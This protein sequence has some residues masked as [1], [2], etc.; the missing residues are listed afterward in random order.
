MKWFELQRQF[1]GLTALPVQK[2]H[3]AQREGWDQPCRMRLD[4]FD[5]DRQTDQLRRHR[6]QVGTELA[7]S[8]HNQPMQSAPCRSEE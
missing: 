3:I 6:L 7:D 4:G 2:P 1:Q 8:R 5:A